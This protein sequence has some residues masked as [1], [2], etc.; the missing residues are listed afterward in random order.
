MQEEGRKCKQVVNKW[1][2]A[3]GTN[4]HT[5]IFQVA[6][7]NVQFIGVIILVMKLHLLKTPFVIYTHED[8]LE[9]HFEKSYDAEKLVKF[10]F[11]S[12]E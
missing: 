12:G 7:D 1:E 3:Q 4:K 11:K 10:G 9:A 5:R 6:N 8:Q 2:K